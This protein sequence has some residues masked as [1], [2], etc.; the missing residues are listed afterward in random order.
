VRLWSLVERL[1]LHGLV[2]RLYRVELSG[3]ERVPLSGGGI[4]VSN[5]ESLSDPVIV[6]LATRRR[7]RFVAKAE[8]WRLPLLGAVMDS[9]GAVPVERGRGDTGAMARAGVLLDE[10]ELIGMF[11]RGT[12]KPAASRRWQRGAAR[13]ALAHGVPLV[14]I[15]LENTRQL[16]PWRRVR[17]SVGEPI[18]VER[19]APTIAAARSLTRAAELAVE[20]LA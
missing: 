8:L 13:L 4:I 14:P 15:R 3:A 5:H 2:A 18:P 17:I 1:R 19:G 9:F 11:P 10:G 7:V 20:Q 16:V 12:C 6:C